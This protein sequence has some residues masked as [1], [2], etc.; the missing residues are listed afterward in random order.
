ML[1]VSEDRPQEIEEGMT[2]ILESQRQE[3]SDP[4]TGSHGAGRCRNFSPQRPVL[5]VPILANFGNQRH[6]VRSASE[7]HRH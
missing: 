1:C 2:G 7:V 4:V 3:A 5:I 6:I